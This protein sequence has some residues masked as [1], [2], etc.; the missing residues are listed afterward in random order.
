MSH[1]KK[2]IWM[3]ILCSFNFWNWYFFS[4]FI[5]R[6]ENISIFNFAS[7]RNTPIL[8]GLIQK[9]LCIFVLY[10]LSITIEALYNCSDHVWSCTVVRMFCFVY[11]PVESYRL[12]PEGPGFESRSPRIAQARVRLATDTLPQTPH[13]A[14]ALC[15]G[16]TLFLSSFTSLFFILCFKSSAG[17]FLRSLVSALYSLSHR[18]LV[19]L[20]LEMDAA[21]L[22]YPH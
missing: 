11:H 3:I 4:N 8:I 14:G 12:W 20:E 1:K 5:Y 22:L 16:Y 17:L 2:T 19:V 10:D 13:R 18:S 15:T 6:T 21:C 7:H 9:G